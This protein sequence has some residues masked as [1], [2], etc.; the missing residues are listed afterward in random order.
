MLAMKWEVQ[1]PPLAFSF[2]F[3]ELSNFRFIATGNKTISEVMVHL[4]K[5]INDSQLETTATVRG[6]CSYGMVS[7][8]ATL[9]YCLSVS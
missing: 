1:G 9:P 8:T 3:F 2:L 6:L 5:I 7:H 4:F